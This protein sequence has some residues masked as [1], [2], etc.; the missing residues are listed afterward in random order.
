MKIIFKRKK[1]FDTNDFDISFVRGLSIEDGAATLSAYTGK[2]IF[3]A[4]KFVLRI[5][6][7]KIS[8]F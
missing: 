1:T 7:T 3:Q 4:F 6:T 2:I 5:T 8:M